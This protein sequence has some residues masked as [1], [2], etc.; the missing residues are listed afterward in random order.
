MSTVA[1]RAGCSRPPRQ[2]QQRTNWG[3]CGRQVIMLVEGSF[4]I[5]LVTVKGIPERVAPNA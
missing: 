1:C 2:L 5:T 4:A 3:V